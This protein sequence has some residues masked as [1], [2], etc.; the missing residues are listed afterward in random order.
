MKRR[1]RASSTT[2]RSVMASTLM[3]SG[4]NS[5]SVSCRPFE[6]H[7]AL[8]G[9]RV[10]H[11]QVHR[12]RWQGHAGGLDFPLTGQAVRIRGEVQCRTGVAVVAGGA[13]A[14]GVVSGR[15]QCNGYGRWWSG[16]R[17][18]AWRTQAPPWQQA[19]R[20]TLLARPRQPLR[21]AAGLRDTSQRQHRPGSPPAPRP[22]P[23]P[24]PAGVAV[25]PRCAHPPAPAPTRGC[26]RTRLSSGH[27]G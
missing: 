4:V 19:W 7:V 15:R 23:R 27:R 21:P 9:R 12:Q 2:P 11:V 18:R 6:D 10:V 3:P 25:A 8:R 22:A 17:R 14:A 20:A 1:P 24:M 16:R 13:T 5:P 26:V